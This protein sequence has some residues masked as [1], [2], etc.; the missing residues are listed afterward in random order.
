MPEQAN[1]SNDALLSA[2][3]GSLKS[4]I[5]HLQNQTN[6]LRGEN[7]KLKD[8][9]LDPDYL[10]RGRSVSKQQPTNVDFETMSQKELY[11]RAFTDAVSAIEKKLGPI[12]EKLSEIPALSVTQE[13]NRIVLANDD[14]G[15]YNDTLRLATFRGLAQTYPNKSLDDLYTETNK[16]TNFKKQTPGA[17]LPQSKE[18]VKTEKPGSLPTNPQGSHKQ[19]GDQALESDFAKWFPDLAGANNGTA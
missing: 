18:P 1:Q 19:T 14:R 5:S 10:D 12:T 6:E 16:L 3:L 7:K 8:H 15:F 11:D 13:I 17:E 9:I 2:E 4:S